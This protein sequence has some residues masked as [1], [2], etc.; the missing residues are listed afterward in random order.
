MKPIFTFLIFY[1]C[2]CVP[3]IAQNP[4][5]PLPLWAPANSGKAAFL[6]IPSVDIYYDIEKGEYIY[7]NKRGKLK[8]SQQLPKHILE[9]DLYNVYKV[10]LNHLAPYLNYASDRV[11]YAGFALRRGQ[12]TVRE[13][14][15]MSKM[16]QVSFT[17][18]PTIAKTN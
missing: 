3:S 1:L 13:H 16:E 10:I 2:F 14:R 12:Q 4:S 7:Q 9:D 8:F 18:E 11:R 15:I 5:A 17:E 6:Y